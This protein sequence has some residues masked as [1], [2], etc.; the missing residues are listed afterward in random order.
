M[1]KVMSL[2]SLLLLFCFAHTGE[3]RADAITDPTGDTFG[4]ELIQHD[5]TSLG[6][7]FT[8][9]SITFTVT[10]A[11][12]VSPASAALPWSV[13]GFI[14]IDT[15]QEAATGA[16]SAINL[17][18][19]GPAI[20]LG[21]EFVIDLFSE[22]TQPGQVDIVN[23]NLD[24]V[25]TAPIIFS[26]N[27]FSVTLPLRLLADDGWLNYGVIVGTFLEA[28]DRAPNGVL[29]AASTPVPEPATMLLL[30]TGL[31]GIGAAARRRRSKTR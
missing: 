6:A 22:E 8:S 25:G 31:A 3:A 29:P 1:L 14:D 7:E 10:F 30:G 4:T 15:D 9:S 28:T 5:I 13:V 19:P 27:A 17:L 18:G 20:L 11:G 2:V 16:E 24:I 12:A 23:S 21:D 26:S